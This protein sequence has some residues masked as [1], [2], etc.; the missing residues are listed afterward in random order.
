MSNNLLFLMAIQTQEDKRQTKCPFPFV[1]VNFYYRN[2]TGFLGDE[3]KGIRCHEV[4]NSTTILT[5]MR[6]IFTIKCR[7]VFLS[8]YDLL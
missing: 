8:Y 6:H 1:Q 3:V 5:F 7:N 2:P 4:L